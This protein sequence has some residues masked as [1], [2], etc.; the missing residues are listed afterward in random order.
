LLNVCE[1]QAVDVSTVGREGGH[2]SIGENNSG[3]PPL[4]QILAC[5]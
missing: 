3:P 2:F 5:T 4:M 1:A